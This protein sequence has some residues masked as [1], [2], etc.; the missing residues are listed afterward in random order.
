MNYQDNITFE[1]GD[2]YGDYYITGDQVCSK[3]AIPGTNN[4]SVLSTYPEACAAAQ[5]VQGYLDEA[6][7]AQNGPDGKPFGYHY[8]FFGQTE[9]KLRRNLTLTVG[10][11]DELNT[12]FQDATKDRQLRLPERLRDLRKT[13]L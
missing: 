8:D 6:D 1:V 7:Q 9:I 11:R 3:A 4:A 5:F 13:D 10:L 12:P 2:E